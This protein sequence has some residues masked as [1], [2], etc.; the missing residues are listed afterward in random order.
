MA[1]HKQFDTAG[2]QV[3]NFLFHCHTAR[4]LS[5]VES[6]ICNHQKTDHQTGFIQA[7]KQA[8]VRQ[9]RRGGVVKVV[10]TASAHTI[11][12]ACAKTRLLE[13]GQERKGISTARREANILQKLYALVLWIRNAY[14]C[15]L[16]YSAARL[17]SLA[18]TAATSTSAKRFAGQI[19]AY[20]AT[21]E[22]SSSRTGG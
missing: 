11:T 17:A 5:I 7:N 19:K 12:G 14:P 8:N 10:S 6:T 3:L 15:F 2:S 4:K 18:A 16:A 20:V 1:R 13:V 21:F 9:V 22:T